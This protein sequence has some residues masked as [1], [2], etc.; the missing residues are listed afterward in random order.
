MQMTSILRYIYITLIIINLVTFLTKYKKIDFIFIYFLSSII[1]YAGA[2]FGKL[3]YSYRG[4]LIQECDI[5]SNTY[6][7]LII[8]MLLIFIC[9]LLPEKNIVLRKTK[10]NKN[11][12][13]LN[14]EKIAMN[15]FFLLCFVLSLYSIL[16]LN[17]FS[18]TGKFNKTQLLENT[19]TIIEY[20]KS[21]VMFAVVYIF[22]ETGIKYSKITY[23]LLI[24]SLFITF[25]LGHRSYII[26]AL[27]AIGYYY[28][29]EKI[30]NNNIN[31]L[32][33]IV[34][35]YKIILLSLFVIFI[36][37]AIKGVTA[38]LFDNNMT[39]VKYRLTNLEYYINTFKTSEPNTITMNLDTIIKNNYRLEQSSYPI[40]ITLF[41]PFISRFIQY[42]SFT[43]V[44][45]EV[46]FGVSNRA[47]T[48]IG[49]A[50]ANGGILAV[51]LIIIMLLLLLKFI[52]MKLVN[53]KNNIIRTFILILGIDLSFYIHRNSMD[54][55]FIRIRSYIYI[56]IL[57]Y[58]IKIIS[59]N[60][61]M[62]KRD[63]NKK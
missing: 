53:C 42:T 14:F 29:N 1:Y 54:Y 33:S 15:V 11:N 6:I 52:N 12:I 10:N 55:V 26:I 59:A 38:A 41:V 37:F 13:N 7:L 31:L 4:N 25:F 50:F 48:F 22:T 35:N 56:V 60:L 24:F 5:N 23:C 17:L 44:Y 40:L 32:H 57:I 43:Y 61:K 9:T 30:S 45:Q 19:G 46:L 28:Y 34:K 62:R 2:I 58:I 3:Y 18:N 36:T 16:K 51:V 39:L 47:S 63:V 49:E 8:N 21:I 27:I 20:F